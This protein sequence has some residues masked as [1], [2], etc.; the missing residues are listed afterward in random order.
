[1]Q[2]NLPV[3]SPEEFAAY[4]GLQGAARKIAEQKY[5]CGPEAVAR[6]KSEA[7]AKAKN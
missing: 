5:K 6:R 7:K 3:V 4:L 2:K 1:L